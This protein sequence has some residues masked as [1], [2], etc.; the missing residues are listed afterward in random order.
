MIDHKSSCNLFHVSAHCFPNFA[1][2]LSEQY[3]TKW[4]MPNWKYNIVRSTL[5]TIKWYKICV[6]PVNISTILTIKD[7]EDPAN[8][9]IQK[10]WQLSSSTCVNTHSRASNGEECYCPNRRAN[11]HDVKLFEWAG[12]NLFKSVTKNINSFFFKAH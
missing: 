7:C 2:W 6:E 1:F 10:M 11:F 9:K 5:L 3:M 12:F 4:I 8:W